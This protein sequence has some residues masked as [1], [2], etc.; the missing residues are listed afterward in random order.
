MLSNIGH[1]TISIIG[2]YLYINNIC[3]LFIGK[4]TKKFVWKIMLLNWMSYRT[5]IAQGAQKC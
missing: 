4:A 3:S 1:K 5:L 2:L